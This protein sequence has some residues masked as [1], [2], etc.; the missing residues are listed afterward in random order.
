MLIIIEDAFKDIS[1]DNEKIITSM[2]INNYVKQKVIAPTI[3][4]KYSKE[5]LADLIMI[6]ALKRVLSTAEIVLVLNDLK[7]G[8][9]TEEAYGVFCA[10]FESC[11]RGETDKAA[12]AECPELTMLALKSLAGKIQFDMV[13]AQRAEKSAPGHV[14]TE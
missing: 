9:D 6:T 10:A 8:R 4:K 12:E 2:I 3:K 13:A 1:Q 5:H 14:I 7:D 11:I